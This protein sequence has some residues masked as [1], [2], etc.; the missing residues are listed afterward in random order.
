MR[1]RQHRTIAAAA[2]LLMAGGLSA[3][4]DSAPSA[5]A[6][7]NTSDSPASVSS[8]QD[9]P[10][11]ASSPSSAESSSTESS[12]STESSSSS[13]ST[14]S[15][16][17]SSSSSSSSSSASESATTA[18]GAAAGAKCQADFVSNP[19]E[20][21][22]DTKMVKWGEPATFTDDEGRKTTVKVDK[23]KITEPGTEDEYTF[24]RNETAL[25]LK[26]AMDYDPGDVSYADSYQSY[27]DFTLR[28]AGNNIC[29]AAVISKLAPDNDPLMDGST[30]SDRT[31]H[32]DGT[33]VF[34]VP[35]DSDPAKFVLTWTG[36][37]SSK[38]A[39]LGW[40]N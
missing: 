5:A 20:A 26:V 18:G 28:D 8:Q 17:A 23:G 39:H 7:S 2:V 30:L 16:S 38:K 6:P 12:T 29:S 35:V 25:V 27:I 15:S 10:S 34:K 40:K 13:S 33:L 19:T 37:S 36:N 22:T 21:D 11:S 4:N 3:C 9:S 31:K 1:T 14:E 24:E 32:L